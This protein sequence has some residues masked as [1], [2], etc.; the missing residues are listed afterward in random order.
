MEDNKSICIEG[1]TARN[2]D[3]WDHFPWEPMEKY[4]DRFEHPLWKAYAEFGLRGGHGGMDYLVL[5]GFVESVQ[6]GINTPID[7]Y[8]TAAW[9]SITCLS[10]QSVAM[11]SMPVPVP[12]FTDGRWIGRENAVA[13]MYALDDIYEALY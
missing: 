5:R 1:I 7:V 6:N 8:D 12:D 11:G 2:P 10:E 4:I 13:S 3:S 9:M